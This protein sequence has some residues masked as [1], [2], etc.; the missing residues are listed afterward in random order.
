MGRSSG[1]RVTSCSSRI[2]SGSLRS[3]D[4]AH[5]PSR[6]RGRL[7]LAAFPFSA[8]SARGLYFRISSFASF[9]Q[10]VIASAPQFG[11][12]GGVCDPA[13]PHELSGFLGVSPSMGHW[14]E[15][16]PD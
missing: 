9:G 8:R 12:A 14:D 1:T 6:D 5:S 13:L 4:G 2:A 3:D 7:A 10:G 16:D 15:A 11:G